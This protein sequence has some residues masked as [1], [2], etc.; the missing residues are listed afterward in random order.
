MK[1]LSKVSEVKGESL[2]QSKGW[3]WEV[4]TLRLRCEGFEKTI[5]Y[6]VDTQEEVG[7]H[8]CGYNGVRRGNYFEG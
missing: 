7:V 1:E 3:E 4:G 5:L 6:N 8:V 2:Q